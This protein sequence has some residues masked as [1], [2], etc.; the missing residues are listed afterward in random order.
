MPKRTLR[1][2]L[3]ERRAAL[4]AD[5]HARHS[6]LVQEHLLASPYFRQAGCV[7]LY[8]SF[9]NEVSTDLLCRRAWA[10]GKRVVYPRVRGEHL[11]FLDVDPDTD[12]VVGDFGVREPVGNGVVGLAS[13]ELL[14]VPGV[15]FDRDGH[16]LGYGRG[17]YDR[18]LAGSGER[19]LRVGL[20]FELQ[21]VDH[22]PREEHDVR[23]HV[24]VTEAGV[25][26]F[27]EP[28]RARGHYGPRA[29]N[30]KRRKR[31]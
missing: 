13:I 12:W 6:R 20:A 14:V 29:E 4:D 9:R 8:W 21:V 11:E 24:L 5:R 25:R 22:V 26:E 19:P 16:R 1:S 30:R 15:V 17:Y 28:G 31:S 23:L 3:L 18:A 7:G 27:T 2:L 10:D